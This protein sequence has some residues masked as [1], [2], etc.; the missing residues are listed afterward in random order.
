MPDILSRPYAP[1]DL[2]ACLA[3]FDSNVPTYFAPSERAEFEAFLRGLDQA[4]GPYLVLTR[5]GQ[6]VACGGVL[7][8]NA[9]QAS[10]AWGMVGRE[11]HRQGL[12]RQLAHVRLAQARRMP[13]ITRLRLSTSQ[14]S[15]GFYEA[16]GFA[17]TSV[18]PDGLA[19]GLD[20]HDMVMRL[21]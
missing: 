18:T 2:A 14:H 20:R 7:A 12:G 13:S 15:A 5:H 11:W 1:V 21:D 10:F 6:I 9:Q 3:L 8:D 17:T 4:S 16:M 19:P